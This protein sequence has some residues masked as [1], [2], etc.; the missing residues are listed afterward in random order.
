METLNLSIIF[1][2]SNMDEYTDLF[3]EWKD[4]EFDEFL[5]QKLSDKL[6]NMWSIL[7]YLSIIK[8][9]VSFIYL[10]HGKDRVY[11]DNNVE[12]QIKIS[13][14]DIIVIKLADIVIDYFSY[15]L[16]GGCFYDK[17]W[18]DLLFNLKH[19]YKLWRIEEFDMIE[20]WS[21]YKTLK[22]KFDKVLK[23]TIAK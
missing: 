1:D 10:S 9:P 18:I 7:S 2:I 14:E 3:F 6:D 13:E 11:I 23:N 15:K 20:L 12:T 4:N 16:W 5:I 17:V 8:N 21:D 22:K 19:L